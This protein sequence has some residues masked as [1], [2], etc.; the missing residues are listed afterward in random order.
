MQFFANGVYGFDFF[1]VEAA[2]LSFP[3][4]HVATVAALTAALFFL[5][6]RAWRVAASLSAAVLVGRVVVGAHYPSDVLAGAACGVLG[7]YL[8]FRAFRVRRPWFPLHSTATDAMEGVVEQALA[9]NPRNAQSGNR[10]D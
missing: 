10:R 7:A 5:G 4:G 8:V 3:S 1:H 2:W 6:S 9:G